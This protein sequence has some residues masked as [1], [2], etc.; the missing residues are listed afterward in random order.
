MSELFD[1][2]PCPFCGS[3]AELGFAGK[4]FY[5]TDKHGEPRTNGFYY[6]V[7]CKNEI[8][9]CIIG[10]YE[11]PKMAIEAWNRRAGEKGETD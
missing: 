6:T 11:E 10:T 7:K 3:L 9:G 8:C 2:K 1:L 5:Y 4:T